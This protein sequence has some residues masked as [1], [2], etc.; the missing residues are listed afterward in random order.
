MHLSKYTG[1]SCSRIFGTFRKRTLAVNRKKDSSQTTNQNSDTKIQSLFEVLK[2]FQFS[3]IHFCNK[4]PSFQVNRPSEITVDWNSSFICRSV[5]VVPLFRRF[6]SFICLLKF[7][8]SSF[9]CIVVD[10]FDQTHST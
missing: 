6:L 10:L 2:F 3:K 7:V 8:V 9:C 5:F 4:C 1:Q